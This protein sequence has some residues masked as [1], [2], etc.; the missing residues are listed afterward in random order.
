MFWNYYKIFSLVHNLSIP[1]ISWKS[2]RHV[3]SYAANRET[4][5]TWLRHSGRG[6]QWKTTYS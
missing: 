4:D 6:R 5:N 2:A 1:Q 3:L